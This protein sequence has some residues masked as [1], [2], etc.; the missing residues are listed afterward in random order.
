MGFPRREEPQPRLDVP[1]GG[2]SS[3]STNLCRR[4]SWEEAPCHREVRSLPWE[5]PPTPPPGGDAAERGPAAAA[6]TAWN[7]PPVRPCGERTT[8]DLFSLEGLKGQGQNC[9]FPWL[10]IK[11]EYKDIVSQQ[12][13]IYLQCLLA[14]PNIFGGL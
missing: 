12:I 8:A 9:Q 3:A 1:S 6:A 2:T 7:R 4:R 13:C 10:W 11:T 14:K 5:G